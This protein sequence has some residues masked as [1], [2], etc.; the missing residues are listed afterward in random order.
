MKWEKT[1]CRDPAKIGCW[2]SSKR[3]C[4]E[5]LFRIYP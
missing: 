1:Q 5:Y 4:S 2:P 3:D